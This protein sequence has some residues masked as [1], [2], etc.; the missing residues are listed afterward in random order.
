MPTINYTDTGMKIQQALSGNDSVKLQGNVCCGN[1]LM[2]RG[3][4]T[5]SGAAVGDQIR[6]ARLPKGAVVV[7][8]LSRV[9]CDALGTTFTVKI[10]DTSADSR[11]AATLALATAG[12]LTLDGTA[13]LS[14]EP[15]EATDWITATVTAV[16][17][18]AAGKKAQFW[19]AYIMP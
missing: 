1:I 18:P 15:L 14:P 10:G 2:A 3:C 19:I 12:T 9:I 8:H 16:A 6:I 7:P 11:Y 5:V 13:G 17:S 4:Y